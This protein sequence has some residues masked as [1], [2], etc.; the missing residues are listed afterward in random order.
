[1]NFLYVGSDG[2]IHSGWLTCETAKASEE[3]PALLSRTGDVLAPT[4]VRYLLAPRNPTA[5]ERSL[6]WR[7]HRAGFRVETA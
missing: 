3:A 6:L 2:R 1:M 4:D 5:D 7:A